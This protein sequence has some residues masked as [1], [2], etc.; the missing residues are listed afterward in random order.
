MADLTITS[1][2]IVESIEQFDLPQAEALAVGNAVRLDATTG[3]ATGAN[4]TDATEAAAIG[5]V[6]EEDEAGVVVTVVKRGLLDVGEALAALDFG[7]PVYLSDTDKALA[8]AAGTVPKIVGY[9]A[10]GWSHTTAD[11]LLRV[12]L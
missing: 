11:R 3:G 2:R 12:N 4:G 8:D 1:V 7:D 9:V 5:I 10:P 6:T